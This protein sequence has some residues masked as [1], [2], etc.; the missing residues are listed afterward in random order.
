M[1]KSKLYVQAWAGAHS[2][3][4]RMYINKKNIN[5]IIKYDIKKI[6]DQ[7][8][9]F[10]A[11]ERSWYMHVNNNANK[12]YNFCYCNDCALENLIWTN[13]FKKYNVISNIYDA[14]NTVNKITYRPLTKVHDGYI[15]CDISKKL[16]ILKQLISNYNLNKENNIKN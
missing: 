6:E 4:I 5:N 14:I 7:F 16:D 8:F 2:S 15:W 1:C 9:Y 13:Y 11:I 12:Q 10:N 3:E